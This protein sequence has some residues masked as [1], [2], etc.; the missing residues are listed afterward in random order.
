MQG[1]HRGGCKELCRKAPEA[2]LRKGNLPGEGGQ[3]IQTENA[4]AHRENVNG[5]GCFRKTGWSRI[6]M[7]GRI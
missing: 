3:G 5:A 4:Q 2:A 7:K 1:E 6:I